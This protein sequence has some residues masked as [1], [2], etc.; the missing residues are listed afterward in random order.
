MTT[1]KLYRLGFSKGDIRRGVNCCLRRIARGRYVATGSCE[2]ARHEVIWAALSEEDFEEFGR[3]G[4]MRDEIEPLRVLIRTRAERIHSSSGRWRATKGR[5]VFS[6]LSAALVHGLPIAYSAQTRVEVFRPNVSRK[7][8]H[9][10]VRNREI[11]SAHRK[12]LG[13]YA[14]TTMER[15]LIDIARDYDLDMSVPML[16]EAIRRRLT[17]RPRLEAVLDECPE[18]RGDAAVL[19]ALNLTDGRR[20]APSESIAAVRFFEHGIAGFEPQVEF[21]DDRGEVIARVDFCHRDAKVIIEIDGLEKYTMDG[22]NPR[23]SIA[24]EK[25]REAALEAR[26]YKVIRL[27]FGELFRTAPFERILG[28]LASRLRTG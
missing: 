25:T 21:R 22:R 13:I 4:D 24:A 12:M 9:L 3:Q 5:E 28:V 1:E 18:S 23:E 19:R 14:V 26:G 2:D 10:Y 7:Y 6:H 11:P 8:R 27:T 20:E 15:T 16:D 17:T